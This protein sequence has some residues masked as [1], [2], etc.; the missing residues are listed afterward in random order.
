MPKNTNKQ[1]KEQEPDLFDMAA[2][3]FFELKNQERLQIMSWFCHDCGAL[4][5]DD[6]D[7]ETG[8]HS[9]PLTIPG[10]NDSESFNVNNK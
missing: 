8:E 6:D 5:E 1:S 4:I 10:N 3:L 9:F 2:G 7:D